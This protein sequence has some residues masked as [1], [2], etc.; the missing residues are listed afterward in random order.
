MPLAMTMQAPITRLKLGEAD[1][2]IQSMAK[3]HRMAVYLNGPT[4]EGGELAERRQSATFD[5]ALR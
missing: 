4:T 1:Q 2:K 5:P 3:A